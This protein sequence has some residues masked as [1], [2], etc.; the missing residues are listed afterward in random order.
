MSKIL[1]TII[2]IL[3]VLVVGA[4]IYIKTTAPSVEPPSGP[5]VVIEC[6]ANEDCEFKGGCYCGC[7]A[8]DY[9]NEKRESM[10]CT[11]ETTTGSFPECGCVNG[12]CVPITARQ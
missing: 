3:V 5:D 11:C 9:K 1:V 12:K 8:K 2:I 10:F 6:T 7:Y 4:V